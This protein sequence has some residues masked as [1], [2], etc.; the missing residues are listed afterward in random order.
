MVC[1]RQNIGQLDEFK[2]IAD[3]YGAILRLTWLRPSGR[4]ADVGDE[5]HPLPEQQLELY[6]SLMAHGED[7]LVGDSF[8]HL[9]PFGEPLPGLKLSGTSRW[10]A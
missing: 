9:A 6:Q 7:A 8:F 1:R 4:G 10:C 5:L 2:T 3:H